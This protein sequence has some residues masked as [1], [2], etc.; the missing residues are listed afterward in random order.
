MMARNILSPEL[1]GHKIVQQA[2]MAGMRTRGVP[3]VRTGE[4]I[5]EDGCRAPRGAIPI[6]IAT[7]LDEIQLVAQNFQYISLIV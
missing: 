3:M 7:L 2:L 5:L 1:L 4:R 6:S